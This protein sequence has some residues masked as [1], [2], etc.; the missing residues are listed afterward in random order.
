[1]IFVELE[2]NSIVVTD[3][4]IGDALSKGVPKCT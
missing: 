4:H 2:L 3:S 1:M